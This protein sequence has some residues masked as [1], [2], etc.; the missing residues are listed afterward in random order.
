MNIF[1]CQYLTTFF[2]N[3]IIFIYLYVCV[4]ICA[5]MC[6]P[7]MCIEIRERNYRSLFSSSTVWITVIEHWL[8]HGTKCLYSLSN[9][10]STH[11]QQFYSILFFDRVILLGLVC[12]SIFVT[13]ESFDTALR[14]FERTTLLVQ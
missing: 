7:R 1:L 12:F 13:I 9:L 14:I 2:S 6:L 4:H 11:L 5:C 3:F 10:A 8:R